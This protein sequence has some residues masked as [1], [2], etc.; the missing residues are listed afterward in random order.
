MAHLRQLRDDPPRLCRRAL[1]GLT[2]L[3]A[4][5]EVDGRAAGVGFCFGGMAV[6]ALARQ[7]TD[8]AGVISMHGS[9]ATG[10]PAVPG[11]VKAK[12]LVCHGARDPHVPLEDVTA[13]IQEMTQAGADWQLIAYG[14]AMHGFTHTAAVPAA[15]PGVAYDAMADHRSF[16]AARQFLTELFPA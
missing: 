15:T 7:Q 8:L 9:L 12:V 10:Q 13:F 14:T 1:A 5:P 4:L 16:Q 2:A 3:R 11:A 6:L